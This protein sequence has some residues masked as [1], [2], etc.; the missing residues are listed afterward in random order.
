MVPAS[1]DPLEG[2]VA[3]AAEGAFFDGPAFFDG[4]SE[5]ALDPMLTLLVQLRADPRPDTID[6]GIGVYRDEDGRTPVMACVKQ[7]EDHLVRHQSSKA[8]LSAD[9]DPA[10]LKRLAPIVLGAE[11][12]VDPRIAGIQTPGGTGALRLAA[13]LMARANTKARVW[14]GQPTWAQHTALMQAG[15]LA[16]VDYPFFDRATQSILFDD[17]MRALEDAHAGDIVLLHGCCHNPTGAELTSAQWRAVT[18]LVQRKGLLPLI[19]IA[20]QGLG[21]GFDEDASGLRGMLDAVPE[22]VVCVS[23]SKNFGLY[24]DRVGAIWIKA[25]N[26]DTARR[27]RNGLMVAA[28]TLWS[29]PP[30]HGASVVRTVLESPE[31]TALWRSEVGTMRLRLHDVH[32]RLAAALPALAGVAQQTGMFALLPLPAGAAAALRTEHGIY[33]MDNGRI[34]IAGLSDATLPRFA[35]AASPYL[36]RNA[37]I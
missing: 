24:R 21:R 13:A 27:A 32:Q 29:M 34:N 17:M 26:A 16:T 1:F 19:D 23:C 9:G 6:L 7:A 22:A 33:L 2:P 3:D 8:Y 12:A 14:L 36:T 30:D 37:P 28:R 10:F 18:A 20:Y 31:L 5:Q 35:E 15:G 4:I 11:H 25:A